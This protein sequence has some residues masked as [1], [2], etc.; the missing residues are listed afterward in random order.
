MSQRFANNA[1]SK[2]ALALPDNGDTITLTAGT[3]GIFPVL[4]NP[5]DYFLVTVERADGSASEVIRITSHAA[6]SDTLGRSPSW[7]PMRG[8]EG[9]T[10][11]AF[12]IGDTV[13]LRATAGSMQVGAWNISGYNILFAAHGDGDPARYA[14]M[15][16][17]AATVAGPTP[18]AIST[19]VAR[20][21]RFRLPKSLLIERFYQ[22]GIAATTNQYGFAIYRTTDGA[23]LLDITVS[24]VANGWGVT[25]IA[26][27]FV[28]L[29]ADTD[30]WLAV[31]ARGTGTVAGMRSPSA[32]IHAAMFQRTG[33]SPFVLYETT[34][35]L[36]RIGLADY[37]QITLATASTFP[38]TLPTLANPAYAGGTTGSVPFVFLQ[39]TAT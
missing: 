6:G 39:G 36:R 16:N 21:V 23:R 19:T 30:Y 37:A 13:E 35:V 26:S 29:D 14:D 12:S 5:Q 32:P 20:L 18:A 28:Q 1:S 11:L 9:T 2:L 33:D 17:L 25:N 24:T 22:F 31:A 15:M 8:Q 7:S 34:P 3:G 10:P 4:D 38:A 27:P